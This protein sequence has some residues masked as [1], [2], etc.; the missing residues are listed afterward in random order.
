MFY[1]CRAKQDGCGHMNS[2]DCCDKSDPEDC[3]QAILFTDP[4]T[5]KILV[6]NDETGNTEFYKTLKEGLG[7]IEEESNGSNWLDPG[8]FSIF[9]VYVN[10][11]LREHKIVYKKQQQYTVTK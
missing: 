7:Y 11:A 10:S 8:C 1:I 9:H 2:R 3:E 6:I 5:Q 4:K